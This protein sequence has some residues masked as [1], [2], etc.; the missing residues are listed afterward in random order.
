MW[1]VGATRLAKAVIANCFNCRYRDKRLEQQQ[2]G[3]LPQERLQVSAPFKS[4]AL[5]LFG[6]FWVK[7]AAKGRRRFKCWVVAYIC[8][9][10]K[11][12]CLLPCPGYGTDVFLTTHR[13]FTGLY[14][15]PRI[16]YTDH[17]PSLIKASETPDWGEIG[18]K[19][20]AQGTEWRLTAKGCSWRNGLAER[21]IRSARHTLSHEL[22]LGETLDFH[23]FG[24]VL[25]VVAAILNSRPLSVHVSPEGEFH[26]LAPRDILFGRA[27]RSLDAASRAVSFTLDLDQDKALSYMCAQ[28]AKIVEAWKRRWL[29]VVFPDM[30]AR[31]KW[32]SAS[33]N[34]RRGDI[35][36]VKYAK[37]VGDHDWR[38]A[39]VEDAVADNDGVVCTVTVAFR[40]RNKRDTGKPYV[41]KTA[42]KLT[43]GV[44]RF[45]VLLAAD[46]IVESVERDDVCQESMPPPRV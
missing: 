19:I 5:D 4:T 21:V 12:V 41:S 23:Q 44:Q 38:L 2:M 33:R 26:A 35:G 27:S 10:A 17:A 6:P 14:G 31:P 20:G 22:R 39:M 46:E 15:Q 11:A 42:Q 32:K 43:I 30:V 28:Q 1:I 3:R 9:G 34:L 36:H 13:F 7:D 45:A 40:P 37:E 25:T 16:L 24:S 29:D 8:M 18:S